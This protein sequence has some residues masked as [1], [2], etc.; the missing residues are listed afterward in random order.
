MVMVMDTTN[1]QACLI[2]ARHFGSVQF[3][4]RHVVTLV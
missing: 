1:R 2:A 3:H 4:G